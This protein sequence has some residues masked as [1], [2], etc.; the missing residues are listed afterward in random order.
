M[1]E[2]VHRHGFAD[3]MTEKF[4]LFCDG[5]S[6]T[7]RLLHR[8]HQMKTIMAF[9]GGASGGAWTPRRQGNEPCMFGIGSVVDDAAESIS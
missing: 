5:A 8:A 6:P 4:L 7:S 2:I 9:D 3:Y 1:T